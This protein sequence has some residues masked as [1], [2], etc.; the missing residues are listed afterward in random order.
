L[1]VLTAATLSAGTAAAQAPRVGEVRRLPVL[2]L[3]M[4]VGSSEKESRQV[5]YTPPPGW[6]VRSHVVD[7]RTKY[8]SCSYSVNTLPQ[9][10]NWSS[11]QRVRESYKVLIDLAAKAEDTGGQARFTQERDRLLSELRKARSNHHALVVE[12]TARGEGFLKGGSGLELTVTA[13]LVYVGT[14]EDVAEIVAR[15]KEGRK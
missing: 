1:T 5:V 9:D 8:G 6:Y 2:S 3:S 10:W 4:Q 12:A 15:H 11:E 13:E 14:D 7:C